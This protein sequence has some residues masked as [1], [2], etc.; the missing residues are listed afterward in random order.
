MPPYRLW[1]P[2]FFWRL[3][4][5]AV[6]IGSVHLAAA[7][8]PSTIN[9]TNVQQPIDG[10]GFSSAWCGTLS[11][12]KNNALYN[13]LGMS[14]LRIR[15]DENNNWSS[16]TANAS[17][18]HAAG[19]KVMGTAWYGPAA[20]RDTNNYVLPA[21]YADFANWLNQ[22]AIAHN[23]DW[24]SPAN[25]P[26]LGWQQ[27]T[28][29]QLRS[30]TAQYGTNITRPLI[31]AESCWFHDSYSDPI[32]NDTVA[33]PLIRIL[34][35]H[36][37]GVS[38][39][40]HQNALNKGK[41]VWMT[42]YY[43][44]GQNDISACMNIAKNISD[45]MN[46]QMS[47]YFWWWVY[48]TDSNVNLVNSSGTIFKNGYTI[49]QF[50]KWIRPGSARVSADYN[51][52]SN[53]YVTAY[54]NGTNLILVVLNMGT[55]GVS[56]QFNITNGTVAMLEGYRTSSSESMADACG[57]AVSAGSF[58]APLPAQSVTTFVQTGGPGTPAAPSN[59]SATAVSGSQISLAWTNNATN[60]TSYLVERS[61]DNV[62]FTQIASLGAA[63]TTYSDNGL[64]GSSTYYYRVRANNNGLRSSY[65]NTANVTM[66]PGVP[67]APTGLGAIS[68]SGSVSLSWNA[69]G[70]TPATSYNIKRS[71]TSGG[72]YTGIG[73]AGNTNY[74][75]SPVNNWMTYYY[76]VSGV[77]GYG[78]SSNSVQV[79]GTPLATALPAPWL[80]Q[81]IGSVGQ[82]GSGSYSNTLFTVAGSGADIWGNADAFHFAYLTVTGDGT[83]IARVV[84]VTNT[85]PWA[86]AGVM[87]RQNLIAGSSHAMLVVTPGNGASF[88]WRSTSGGSMSQSQ[89]T[90]ISAPY[91]VKLVRSG[92]S[93]SGYL[94]PDGGAWRQVGATQTITMT[95]AVY[96]G[97][98]V[99]A[100]N[101][102]NLC[103]STFDNVW[104]TAPARPWQ[105]QDIGSVG[106][107]GS[108]SYSNSPFTVVG[109]GADIWGNAD[110]FNYAYLPTAGDCTVIARVT[111]VQNTDPWA[112]GGV[113][114]RQ[115]LSPGSAHAM[116]VMTPGN[117]ASFQ[118]RS[119]TG[120]SMSQSQ[121]NGRSAP[122]WVKLVRSGSNFS[123]Y[124]SVDS[125]NWSQV[126]STQ[127]IGMT[128]G[129]DAGLAVTA[130]SGSS[131]CTATFDNVSVPGWPAWT[132]P[133][134][135]TGLTAVSGTLLVNLNWTQS[136]NPD[137]TSNKVYRSTTGSAGPYNLLAS[138]AATTSYPDTAVSAGSTYF[139]A[140]TAINTN[141]ESTN[142]VQATAT[143]FSPTLGSLVHRYSFL[144]SGGATI[145]DSVGG[146]VWTG[147]LPNGGALSSGQLTLSPASQQ[148]AQLPAGVAGSLSNITLMAWVN[149]NSLSSGSPI[150]DFGYNTT[151]NMY[152]AP[153]SGATGMPRFAITTN[154]TGTEQPIDGSSALSTGAW[155]QVAVAMFSGT[156]VLYLDGAAVGTNGGLSLNP[157]TLGITPNNYLGKSQDATAPYLDGSLKEVRIYNAGLSAAEIAATAALGPSQLLSTN[158][159]P[160]NLAVTQT[161]LVLSWPLECAGYLVQSC[162]DIALGDWQTVTSAVPQI[163]GNQ[164][165]VALP[166][167]DTGSSAFF[168]LSASSP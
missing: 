28:S 27:W 114:I 164:W 91:W 152:L 13:T 30:W 158:S 53:V 19:A 99:T 126:G 87:I 9:W 118:W 161:N 56:Q 108:A 155:H 125:N 139:Y 105:H 150:I 22:A 44:N 33:G 134:A 124:I 45:C 66:Q 70:G 121:V 120:G 133:A 130:H 95:G 39:S 96:F 119:T 50:A 29:D 80:D 160:I 148:Y 49:G 57:Y 98:P 35:G 63:A 15:I 20:W 128:G 165:Q 61:T 38:P 77:N 162:T 47:A 156:G 93:L 48:E 71:T 83:I 129:I 7:A 142:S 167:S 74:T 21:H 59:L 58:T 67:A 8:S 147:T 159:P 149:L 81:D 34:G 109:S 104:S 40:V 84:S 85:D 143:T 52:Q 5:I 42:E 127:T 25:E 3:V 86:K 137:I 11:T 46:C 168:R 146:P 10:F 101:N 6:V 65:S 54:L 37:Y 107:T 36:L 76:V 90:G 4:W 32:L 157:L 26:D 136:T 88:Q 18:A 17:A 153:Q 135:P 144:E 68:R 151:T 92:N 115:S 123:G 116:M 89:V 31:E 60:A 111:S 55:S 138:L 16:E 154:G 117:G 72:P 51:P 140:V 132:P 14:L 69:S 110:A 23:L 166:L 102:T 79:A 24:L 112:K 145:A 1:L 97:L 75:D 82:P 2:G 41:H 106:Q 122:Y 103:T 12:A 141:G 94:S 163:V 78:E 131:L 43:I 113:M 100:H 62:Y 64:P 73:T